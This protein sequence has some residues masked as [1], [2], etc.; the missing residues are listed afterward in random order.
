MFYITLCILMSVVNLLEQLCTSRKNF[1]VVP[2]SHTAVYGGRV[3]SI[4]A[5]RLRNSVPSQIRNADSLSN[6]KS[7]LKTHLFEARFTLVKFLLY[8]YICSHF[9]RC[10]RIEALKMRHNNCDYYKK[11]AC[12]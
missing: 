8:H 3:F 4:A 2:T 1:L 7:L 10:K 6:F 12:C 11:D 5:P 9:Q